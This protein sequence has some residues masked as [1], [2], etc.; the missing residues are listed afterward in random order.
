MC[1]VEED[2]KQHIYSSIS[3][4]IEWGALS[5]E[6]RPGMTIIGWGTLGIGE[7]DGCSSITRRCII[8]TSHPFLPRRTA[9]KFFAFHNFIHDNLHLHRTITCLALPR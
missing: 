7:E 3:I 1:C 6:K 9:S 8:I 2:K 5:E 4:I